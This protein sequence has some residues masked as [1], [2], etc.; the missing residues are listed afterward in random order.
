MIDQS[1]DNPQD[2]FHIRTRQGARIE[3]FDPEGRQWTFNG[4]DYLLRIQSQDGRFDEGWMTSG[5][6]LYNYW[7]RQPSNFGS[8]EEILRSH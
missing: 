7:S 5:G 2:G 3:H 6:R 8:L 4:G 1:W